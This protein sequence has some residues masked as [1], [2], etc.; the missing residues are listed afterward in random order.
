[1]LSLITY[2]I[3]IIYTFFGDEM[4]KTLKDYLESKD[5]HLTLQSAAYN[6][7]YD[8]GSGA[9]SIGVLDGT[10][11]LSTLKNGYY[12]RFVPNPKSPFSPPHVYG[13]EVM[14]EGILIHENCPK[15][16][17]D[18]NHWDKP[19]A[20]YSQLQSLDK[21][22]QIHYRIASS[23][24]G[25]YQ[26]HTDLCKHFIAKGAVG[27]YLPSGNT[28]RK[29]ASS[30]PSKKPPTPEK[31]IE[32]KKSHTDMPTEHDLVQLFINKHSSLRE[33]A[34]FG[35][36]FT[37]THW[38]TPPSTLTEI[39]SHALQ[40]VNSSSKNRSFD[41]CV[42]LGWLSAEGKLKTQEPLLTSAYD[43]AT[44]GPQRELNI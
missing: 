11:E 22:G 35:A 18:T 3:N 42:K 25:G 34:T 29:K 16:S 27:D 2:T 15:P 10:E 23:I 43:I 30:A 32:D 33:N 24:G 21:K 9:D 38:K 5:T 17:I 14:A 40:S 28:W 39:L 41:A 44:N 37:R 36:F 31:P 4:P 26:L 12:L 7:Y 1:L 19:S 6:M 8:I 13:V 20:L